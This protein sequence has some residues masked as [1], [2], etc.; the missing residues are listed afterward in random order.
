MAKKPCA[1]ED[2]GLYDHLKSV[3][4]IAERFVLRTNL[5]K[6][7]SR[8]LNL[9]SDL[10][11]NYLV[12]AA[13]YHDI[14]KAMEYYQKNFDDN[15]RSSGKFSFYNHEIFSAIILLIKKSDV[16][17]VFGHCEL[18]FDLAVYSILMHHHAMRVHD[19]VK[20]VKNFDALKGICGNVIV[21]DLNLLGITLPNKVSPNDINT[22]KNWLENKVL[23]SINN[24]YLY[25]L[26]P[27]IISDYRDATNRKGTEKSDFTFIVEDILNSWGL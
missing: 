13:K 23:N 8:R 20:I 10:V 21:N 4:E 26:L 7:V 22:L 14:G 16:M 27:L 11:K 12:F 1:F 9:S 3:G 5:H 25:F 18:C 17:R 24:S 2:Q 6:V 15:C 19:V